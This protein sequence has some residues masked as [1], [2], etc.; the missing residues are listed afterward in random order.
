MQTVT[1]TI[2]TVTTVTNAVNVPTS[3]N[4]LRTNQRARLKASENSDEKNEILKKWRENYCSTRKEMIKKIVDYMR[5]HYGEEE[6]ESTIFIRSTPAERFYSR[7]SENPKVVEGTPALK[8]LVWC[9]EDTLVLRA[10]RV[11]MAKPLYI[12]PPRKN[13]ARVCKHKCKF[14]YLNYIE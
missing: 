13:R 5:E 12:P 11:K 2:V 7:S 9:F 14:V 1:T 6:K 8:A 10:Q 4:A 3:S